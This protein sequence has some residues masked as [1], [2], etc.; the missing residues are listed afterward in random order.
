MVRYLTSNSGFLSPE[1]VPVKPVVSAAETSA[2]T[3]EKRRVERRRRE[4]VAEFVNGLKLRSRAR[5]LS[6]WVE[7]E[8]G[9]GCEIGE[10]EEGLQRQDILFL[11][12]KKVKNR[13]SDR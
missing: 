8:S 2:V 11:E 10:G 12:R 9:R 6:G 1:S 3:G 7:E 5:N 4:R 13:S